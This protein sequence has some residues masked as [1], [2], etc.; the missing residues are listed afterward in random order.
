[1][2]YYKDALDADNKLES[3]NY[4]TTLSPE[5]N[6][7][8]LREGDSVTLSVEWLNRH[9]PEGCR[10]GV[11]QDTVPYTVTDANEQVIRVL[12]LPASTSLTICKEG[13]DAR[14]GIRRSC[15]G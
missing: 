8:L 14:D 10:D 2:E 3:E 11:Q 6:G 1:M 9:R 4:Q 13:A 7:E 5:H 15:S 12:Y